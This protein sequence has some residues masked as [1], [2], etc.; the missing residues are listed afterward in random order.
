MVCSLGVAFA[1]GEESSKN[2]WEENASLAN[3]PVRAAFDAE[4]TKCFVGYFD[5]KS[6][7]FYKWK[8]IM[9]SGLPGGELSAR[10]GKINLLKAP[11]VKIIEID[12]PVRY[13]HV[14]LAQFFVGYVADRIFIRWKNIVLA[15]PDTFNEAIPK[16][17]LEAKGA[18]LELKDFAYIVEIDLP[19]HMAAKRKLWSNQPEFKE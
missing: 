9:V 1:G 3:L 18:V 14:T 10:V 4:D 15:S 13:A 5:K 17:A 12:P 16:K 11:E 6:S 2:L 19:E 7:T 8:S